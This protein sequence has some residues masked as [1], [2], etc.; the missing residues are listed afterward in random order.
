MSGVIPVPPF[1]SRTRD[2]WLWEKQHF[3]FGAYKASWT[4]LDLTLR[5]ARYCHL[6]RAV[7]EFPK[8]RQASCFRIVRPVNSMSMCLLL[9]FICCEVS[10]F[11]QKQCCVK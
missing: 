11:D 3:I 6:A 9:H 10:S 5:P 8:G 4:P 2:S 7:A 1:D